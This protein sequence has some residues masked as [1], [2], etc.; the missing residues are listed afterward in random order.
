ML[1]IL[2]VIFLII[3]SNYITAMTIRYINNNNPDKLR[4]CEA[5]I[6]ER[7]SRLLTDKLNN[8]YNLKVSKEFEK[9]FLASP[10]STNYESI[11]RY[12]IRK[13]KRKN[14]YSTDQ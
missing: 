1:K 12:I 13:N 5:L 8:I 10:I 3:L 4:E 7:E 11:D 6:E 2:I 9:L 14:K